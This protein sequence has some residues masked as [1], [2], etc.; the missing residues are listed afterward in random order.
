MKRMR[1]EIKEFVEE[2]LCDCGE[3]LV[4]SNSVYCTMPA[5]RDF[6]CPKCGYKVCLR[7]SRW[8]GTYYERVGKGKLV[9]DTPNPP[10]GAHALTGTVIV[11]SSDVSSGTITDGSTTL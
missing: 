6:T 4:A 8:P 9:E 3:P 11:A 10:L 7:E 5:Q 2:L 1:Y